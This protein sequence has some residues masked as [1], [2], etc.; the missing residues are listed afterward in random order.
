MELMT[1]PLAVRRIVCLRQLASSFDKNDN[2]FD[3]SD[4]ENAWSCEA[5]IKDPKLPFR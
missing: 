4:L 3:T 1:S 5:I 2:T